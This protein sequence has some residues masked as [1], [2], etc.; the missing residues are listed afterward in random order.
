MRLLLIALLVIT[1]G[2]LLGAWSARE[3]LEADFG[4]SEIVDGPWRAEPTD[5]TLEASPYDTARW[6]KDLRIGFSGL[7][8]IEFVAATDSMGRPLDASC[9]YRLRIAALPAAKWTLR[10]VDGAGL[11]RPYR[12]GFTSASALRDGSGTA[13]MRL[14]PRLSPDNWLRTPRPYRLVLTL[15]ETTLLSGLT[16]TRAR[17]PAVRRLGC[18]A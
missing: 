12:R 11:D 18:A 6:A 5:G 16:Q 10:V 13:T 4:S 7:E 8:T 14:S 2:T 3:A 9:D 15:Y 17:M 1:A